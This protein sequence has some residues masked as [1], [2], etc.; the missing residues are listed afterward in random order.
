MSHV[1]ISYSR[2]DTDFVRQ[3]HGALERDDRDAWVDWEGIPPSDKWMARIHSAI[4][5]A[6][7]FL[8]VISPDSVESEI[9]DKELKYAVG[10]NKRLI[11]ILHREPGEK[12]PPE[13]AEINYIFA[14]SSD[15]FETAYKVLVEAIDT[16]LDWMRQH[17][18]LLVRAK[19]WDRLGREASYTLR[20]K[21]L[22]GFEDWAA[23]AP[24][25][26]PKPTVL[27]S[28]YLLASRRTVTR[29]QRI[30][31]ALIAGGLIIAAILGTVAWFQNQERNR[32]AK[33]VSARQLL[34]RAEALRDVPDTERDAHQQHSESLRS[35]TK[36]LKIMDQ[37]QAPTF[38]ADQSVRK[39]YRRLSKWR[40]IS[41]G[42]RKIFHV[43]VEA[44]G[45]YVAVSHEFTGFSVS[46]TETGRN[47]GGCDI[48]RSAMQRIG[49]VAIS[50]SARRAA[51][52]RQTASK[53]DKQSTVFVFD[54][55]G[56][57]PV[58]TF[59]FPTEGPR[60]FR[61]MAL[62]GDGETLAVRAGYTLEIFYLSRGTRLR[63]PIEGQ[64]RSLAIS[65]DNRLIATH[66]AQKIDGKWQRRIRLR[67]L[68]NGRI[69][70]SL[71]YPLTLLRL[72]WGLGGLL[73]QKDR[74][75]VEDDKLVYKPKPSFKGRQTALSPDGRLYATLTGGMLQVRRIS[76]GQLVAETSHS[77]SANR[78]A[79]LRNSRSLLSTRL[80]GRSI[81][82]WDF[83]STGP[84][85]TVSSETPVDQIAFDNKGAHLLAYG[86]QQDFRW[87][88]P[89]NDSDG[90]PAAIEPV[91]RPATAEPAEP[92][93]TESFKVLGAA[94]GRSSGINAR[95][96]AVGSTRGGYE[97]VLQVWQKDQDLRSKR[98]EPIIDPSMEGFVV[99]SGRDRF[100]IVAM[101][102]GLDL[103][104]VE[105]LAP[106]RTLY[107]RNVVAV[108]VQADG[109]R[110]V[111]MAKDL[112][113]R[114]WDMETGLE[115]NRLAVRWLAHAL[116]LSNDDRWLATL[117][118]DGDIDI[119]ALAAPDLIL[120]ACRWLNKP[121]P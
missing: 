12:V 4:D 15:S 94:L 66:E 92:P 114:V 29:R 8:F 16:D 93:P 107:H 95:I 65:P 48:D 43:G 72:N 47:A 22:T 60:Q 81:G 49:S 34:S 33:I 89:A 101:R 115:V 59:E 39:S 38:D 106:V 85:A 42:D 14:R 118:A 109:R 27:Q 74:I 2:R 80:D 52:H 50:Q 13:L 105:T 117:A 31:W 28:E 71:E 90:A 32:Q 69:L 79:F 75:V 35:A 9:C 111:T 78:I 108:G 97:R 45:R 120:Q 21:D 61:A 87:K 1:F 17:T 68:S 5:E 91:P 113:V 112:S 26:E 57:Q 100:L 62:S 51:I 24:D 18:R 70:D 104:D 86:D 84:Y 37:L 3:L 46:D 116:A 121:C 77:A 58:T 41:I 44:T 99:L 30:T 110:A 76:S 20:G 96:I 73:T 119:W 56:C 40:G 7:A 36:A 54:L 64:L 10:Q 53:D 102:Q 23:Q 11:P 88:L 25:K 55:P 63:I 83:W 6:E 103:L 82:V 67:T 98:L 19:E